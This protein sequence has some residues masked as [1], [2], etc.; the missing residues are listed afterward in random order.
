MTGN[1]YVIY[2]LELYRR[3]QEMALLDLLHTWISI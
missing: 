3:V 2:L 1:L